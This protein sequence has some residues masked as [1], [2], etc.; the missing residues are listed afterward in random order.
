MSKAQNV[1][2]PELI[3]EYLRTTA[4]ANEILMTDS[5][6]EE[7][8]KKIHFDFNKWA[9]DWNTNMCARSWGKF[10]M[11]LQKRFAHKLKLALDSGAPAHVLRDI[12]PEYFI[13]VTA[14]DLDNA[15]TGVSE[16]NEGT[17]RMRP[18]LLREILNMRMTI[19]GRTLVSNWYIPWSN[20]MHA[21]HVGYKL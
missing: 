1:L 5:Q 9:E 17:V 14:E 7:F 3:M 11:V 4:V 18:C 21:H 8:E 19:N 12:F 13:G 6:L 20:V 16:Q 15:Y 2:D 10:S